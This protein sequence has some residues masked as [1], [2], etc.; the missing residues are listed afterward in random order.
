MELARPEEAFGW[1]DEKVRSLRPP[2][3]GV[4]DA[5]YESALK[6]LFDR[7]FPS[8]LNDTDEW[9][10]TTGLEELPVDD[11]TWVRI[12]TLIFA[13]CGTDLLPFS[14]QQVGMGFAYLVN[15]CFSDVPH[16]VDSPD[17]TLADEALLLRALPL[18]WSDCFA[19]R[20]ANIVQSEPS[21][22]DHLQQVCYMWFDVWPSFW[23]HR[24]EPIWQEGVWRTLKKILQLPCEQCQRSALHGIGHERSRLNRN[25]E[26]DALIDEYLLSVPDSK[27]DLKEYAHDARRG[28]VL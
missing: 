27:R 25:A 15:N 14:N 9:Y 3:V 1:S 12:Q 13:R 26:L 5:I 28:H 20:F 10:W 2:A 21:A 7:P 24:N 22:D 8:S 6:Y 19:P 11:V 17:V 4:A 23:N 18:V 16:A